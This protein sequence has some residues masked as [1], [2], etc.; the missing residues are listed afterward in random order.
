MFEIKSYAR[1]ELAML[2][3]PN[4]LPETASVNFR[5]WL[6]ERKGNDE[7]LSRISRKKILSRL[8]VKEIVEILGE[9]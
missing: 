4:S 1:K 6:N 8:D 2:Y 9:P 7:L 5:R 3:F